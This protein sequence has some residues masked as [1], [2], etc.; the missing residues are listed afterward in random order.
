M[1]LEG[2]IVKVNLNEET[3]RLGIWQGCRID[4]LNLEITMKT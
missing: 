2:L 4:I 3:L 1:N